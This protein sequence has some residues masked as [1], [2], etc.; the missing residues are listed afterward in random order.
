MKV[1]IIDDEKHCIESLVIHL[2]HL[3]PEAEICFKT[4]R[5]SEALSVLP[6][7]DI[8]ILF[9]DIEMPELNGFQLLEQFPDRKFEVIFVTAYSQYAIEAFKVK[10]ISYILK[11]IDEDELK[12]VITDWK[13]NRESN[14]SSTQLK[15]LLEGLKK[16]GILESKIAVPVTDGYCFIEV[17]AIMYCQSQSNY[18]YFHLLGG[19]RELVSK[20]LKEV[21]KTLS[22]F[23]FLRP[24]QS[25]LV[26]PNFLEKYYRNDGGYLE[27]KDKK[28]IPVSA[29]KRGIITHFFEA[30]AR[31]D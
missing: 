22:K 16:D 27:M 21:E 10:A 30:I 1:A 7:L 23:F 8:D 11:P 26:N 29:Q 28:Q 20:T 17:N 15:A 12:A 2:N 14:A 9:L 25:Y 6:Q 4:H 13:K 31:K 19:R 18:T 3:F 5:V 24:H